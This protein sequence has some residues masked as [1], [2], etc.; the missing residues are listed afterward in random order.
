MLDLAGVDHGLPRVRERRGLND[1]FPAAQFPHIV[2]EPHLHPIITVEGNPL[3]GRVARHVEQV[4]RFHPCCHQA[5]PIPALQTRVPG[6]LLASVAMVWNG[7]ISVLSLMAPWVA[8]AM[9]CV[10]PTC[11]PAL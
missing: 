11:T 8:S 10:V 7:T 5:T 1:R 9:A 6:V 3:G 4:D 2:D